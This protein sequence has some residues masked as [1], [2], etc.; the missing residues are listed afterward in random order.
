MKKLVYLSFII[1]S[2]VFLWHVIKMKLSILQKR[3]YQVR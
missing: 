2:V 3:M 1:T